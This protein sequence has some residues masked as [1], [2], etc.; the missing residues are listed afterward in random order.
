MKMDKTKK[1]ALLL[2]ESVGDLYEGGMGTYKGYNRLPKQEIEYIR[3]RSEYKRLKQL[4]R[5]KKVK[6]KK[7][8]DEILFRFTEAGIISVLKTRI[9]NCEIPLMEGEVCIVVFDIPEDIKSVRSALRSLL[10][11]AGFYMIQKSVWE[12]DKEVV[13]DFRLLVH[14]LKADEYIRVYRANEVR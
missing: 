2:L 12:G 9:I 1:L 13:D 6:L 5:R 11:Q 4:E 10:K 3:M 14:I 8:G 7:K